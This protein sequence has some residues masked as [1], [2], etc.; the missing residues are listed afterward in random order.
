[1]KSME[2]KLTQ[3]ELHEFVKSMEAKLSQLELL[4]VKRNNSEWQNSTM[5]L[6]MGTV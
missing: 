4:I 2:A 5:F 3:L 1:M 6:L